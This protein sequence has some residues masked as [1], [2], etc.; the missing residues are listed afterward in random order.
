M[1]LILNWEPAWQFSKRN[2]LTISHIFRT[3]KNAFLY[4][5]NTLVVGA[6]VCPLTYRSYWRSDSERCAEPV[7]EIHFEN[8]LFKTFFG[9]RNYR[10]APKRRPDANLTVRR[11][12]RDARSLRAR[13]P[14]RNVFCKLY[15]STMPFNI[16]TLKKK[17]RKKSH[18]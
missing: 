16:K 8:V 10:T 13:R 12:E 5:R 4:F 7:R 15:R 18:K 11:G 1:Y 17:N 3:N 9:K 6:R 14:R 2:L